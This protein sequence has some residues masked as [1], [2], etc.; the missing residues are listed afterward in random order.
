MHGSQT[1]FQLSLAGLELCAKTDSRDEL[2]NLTLSRLRLSSFQT[3][4][5]HVVNAEVRGSLHAC[6]SLWVHVVDTCAHRCQKRYSCHF[7]DMHTDPRKLQPSPASPN[8]Q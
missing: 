4:L 8:K 2:L 7:R 6:T 1:S 5:E 3:A